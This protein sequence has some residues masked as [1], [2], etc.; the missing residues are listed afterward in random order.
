MNLTTEPF[1]N[2]VPLTVSVKPGPP[3]VALAGVKPVIAELTVR[4]T[5][6]EVP[7]FGFITVIGK[8]PIVCRSEAINFMVI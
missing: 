6:A 4:L 2:P 8:V 5:A 7:P 1:T 3:A